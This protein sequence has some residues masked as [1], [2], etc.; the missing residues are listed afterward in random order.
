MES[1]IELFRTGK[2]SV[3]QR[4]FEGQ[5]KVLVQHPGAVVILPFVDESRIC[6]IRN[7][8]FAVEKTLIELPAGTLEPG[9]DPIVTAAREL[10]EETG[11]RSQDL[12]P[13]FDY[14]VSPGIL[15]EKM[16]AFVARDLV[17]G[18]QNLMQDEQIETEIVPFDEA[19]D[20]I[21]GGQI[22]DAKT[23][24]TLLYYKQFG[25]A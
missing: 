25:M 17:A 15:N 19:I 4:E 12:A 8:R 21:K 11:F 2:F 13:I 9:E 14:Y 10:A 18:E 5:Q 23:I 6:L 24:A 1:P 3:I 7:R 22:E 16:Y 20:L